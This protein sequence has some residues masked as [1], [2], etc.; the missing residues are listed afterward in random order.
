EGLEGEFAARGAGVVAPV[1]LG[2]EEAAGAS[3]V[4]AVDPGEVVGPGIVLVL[5][6]EVVAQR[7]E[8][9]EAAERAEDRG[10]WRLIEE[11]VG[12]GHAESGSGGRA[13][14]RGHP[15]RNW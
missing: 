6:G 3:L 9:A 10:L 7:A 5:G 11:A 13:N 8:D 4:A 1:V 2:E 12:R 14:R 15:V